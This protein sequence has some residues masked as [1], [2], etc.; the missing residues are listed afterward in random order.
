[1]L[2]RVRQA[3]QTH[4]PQI[5][6]RRYEAL[7]L[8]IADILDQMKSSDKRMTITEIAQKVGLSYG[9][10]LHN[11]PELHARV[12]QAVQSQKARIKALQEEKW[13]AL[14]DEAATRLIDQGNKVTG[15]A[16]LRAAG[17]NVG[18]AQTNPTVRKLLHQRIGGFV[19]ND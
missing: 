16:V 10:L 19:S 4:N 13:R 9:V 18:A 14:I 7:S 5:Q 1:L 12:R 3:A 6:Q 11:Y 17:I 2:N 8:Q 15:N